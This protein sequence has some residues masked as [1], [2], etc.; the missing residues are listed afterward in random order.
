M[1]VTD[2]SNQMHVKVNASAEKSHALSN[3]PRD[4][5]TCPTS[6]LGDAEI[7]PPNVK[8]EL[9]SRHLQDLSDASVSFQIPAD[10]SSAEFLLADNSSDLEFLRGACGASFATVAPTPA[11]GTLKLS[12]VTPKVESHMLHPRP[13]SPGP[14]TR[15]RND[16]DPRP[17]RFKH[18]SPV[19]ARKTPRAPSKLKELVLDQPT[20]S[21]ERLESL[22]A[23]VETLK[24]DYDIMMHVEPAAVAQCS[25]IP[26]LNNTAATSP[27]VKPRSIRAN[28]V[29]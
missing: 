12:D 19:K 7:M 23:E 17:S 6:Q 3:F 14:S 29:S 20:I 5:S 24:D 2:A 4:A 21:E 13:P 8:T 18:Q 27:T 10:S 28:L 1:H 22:R 9:S 25:V 16:N 11:R 15:Q 26:T